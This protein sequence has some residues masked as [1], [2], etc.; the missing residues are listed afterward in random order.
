[1][2]RVERA[3][4]ARAIF[5]FFAGL[6]AAGFVFGILSDPFSQIMSV[7]GDY[8]TTSEAAKGR[9]YVQA[10][11]DALP[12]IMVFL[13]LAQLIGAAASERRLPGQ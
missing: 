4:L 10:F 12:F 9:G 3:G 11:W 8:A 2:A 1:M 5:I 13:A 7:G 6:A